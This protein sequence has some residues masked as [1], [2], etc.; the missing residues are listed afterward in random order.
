MLLQ[1]SAALLELNIF[2]K[3]C[4]SREKGHRS[5]SAYAFRNRK[6]DDHTS[7][8]LFSLSSSFSSASLSLRTP[9][10]LLIS[11]AANLS[12]STCMSFGIRFVRWRK[13]RQAV[14]THCGMSSHHLVCPLRTVLVRL[15]PHNPSEVRL[16]K[17]SKKQQKGQNW[18]CCFQRGL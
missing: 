2:L 6:W 1:F 17:R 14:S 9:S 15:T 3:L 18:K 13:K 7:R 16:K 10:S 12:G 4:S 8:T 5:E 11:S